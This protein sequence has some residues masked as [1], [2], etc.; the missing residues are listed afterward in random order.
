MDAYNKKNIENSPLLSVIIPIYKV[1]QFLGHCIESITNQTYKNLEIILVDDGSPD[2]CGKICDEYAQ[3]DSR[4]VVIHQKNQGVSE[5]RNSG[6]KIA[7]GHFSGY[8]DGD[9]WI[10]PEMFETMIL[11]A[12]ENSLDI[13]EC[14]VVNRNK[15]NKPNETELLIEDY[16]QA[17]K[18]II[19]KGE[20]AAWRRIYKTELIKDY[21][22][23]PNK[24][25]MDVNFTVDNV[26]KATRVGYLPIPFY[27]YRYNPS[28]ITKSNYNLKN[29][30]SFY[31]GLYLQKTITENEDDKELLLIVQDHILHKILYHYKL[32][33]YNSHID[34]DRKYRKMIKDLIVKNY[35]KSP[36]HHYYL[37]LARYLPIGLFKLLIKGNK[38]KLK[39]IKSFSK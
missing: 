24:N 2:N 38:V 25:S 30:D 39:I 13:I 26:R 6:I 16:V 32:M 3:R 33:N 1:E 36:K 8:V 15:K 11:T 28:G 17:Y 19:K 7:K 5:A 35:Y 21:R 20:F 27:N 12:I 14:G 37:R 9:D 10:E 22:W 4:I 34:P 31:A 29:L 18:R 23:V